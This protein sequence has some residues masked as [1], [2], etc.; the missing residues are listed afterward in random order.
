MTLLFT[1]LQGGMA[2]AQTSIGGSVYGG[3]EEADVQ[4]DSEVNI[5]GGQVSGNVYGGGKM[6]SVGTIA[7]STKTESGFVISVPYTFEYPVDAGTGETTTGLCTVNVTGGTIGGDV[8]G[9]SQGEAG[10]SYEMALT[11][12]IRRAEVI[13]G[14]E[15][16][17]SA[18][19]PEIKGSVYGG[20]ENGHTIEDAYVTINGG[21]IG[22][23]VFGSG[24][25]TDKYPKTLKKW[26]DD[27]EYAGEVYSLTAGKVY[28]NAYV[29]MKGGHVLGN[30]YGGGK[31][32]SIGKGNYSGGADDYFP[33]GY[34]ETIGGNLWD[35]GSAESQ[36]FLGT[37]KASVR[38]TGGTIGSPDGIDEAAR[39]PTGNVFGGSQGEAAPN[40]F[41]QPADEY[42]PVF[43]VA[44]INEAE[45]IIGTSGQATVSGATG[46]AGA[47]PRIYGSVYGGGQDG[48]IRR[49]AK[50]TIYSGEIGNAY[51][52]S[53]TYWEH[54]GNVFGAGSGFGLYT[55]DYNHNGT[56]YTDSN[57]NGRYDDGEPIDT[58][59]YT[60][61]DEDG[62][63][64]TETY[65][66]LGV[67]YLA[68][69]VARFSEVDIQGGIIHR[70]VYGGGSVAGTGEP[71]FG[72]QTYEPYRKGDTTEGHGQ[73]K[74]SM[75][76]VTVSGGIIGQEGHGGDVYGASRGNE[77]LLEADDRLTTSIWTEVNI[78]PN[79]NPANSPVIYGS[80]YGGG[81]LGTVKQDTK[82]NLLGGEIK[83]D[84]Y[85][86][87]K[88]T[89]NV[90]ADIGSS[91]ESPPN[92][93]GNTKVNLN[94]LAVGDYNA[95]LHSSIV[96]G[97]D[98]NDDGTVDYYRV[99]NNSKG[100]IVR[101]IFGCNNINGTPKGDAEVHVYATQNAAGAAITNPA[102]GAQTAKV[103]G[104]YDVQAVY[105]GGNQSAYE[106]VNALSTDEAMKAR[107]TTN[108][109]IDGCSLTS[110]E[111]V[112][113][114][115][116]AA[117]TPATSVT[118]NGTFEI[119][120]VFGG[121]NGK[122]KITVN[123]ALQDNP[124][125]NVGFRDY[126]DV[127]DDD[128]YNTKEKR[129]TN[130]DFINTYVY[131]SG[132]AS[133]NIFGGKIHRVFGGSNTKG[134]VRKTAVTMLEEAS[135]CDFLVDEAYGGGKSAPMDAEAQLLMECIPGLSAV[136]G[137]AE[138]ADIQDN[139]VLNI[140]NGTF[141]RV[142]GGN[143][144]SGTIKGT[145][146]VNIQETGC[147]PV[148]IGQLYGGGNQAPYTAPTGQP[149]P[150]VN[151]NS[152]TR[153]GEVYGG[154]YG[155]T[156]EVVGDTH[157]NINVF[158][159]RFSETNKDGED[160]V[161]PEEQK[162]IT[163]NEY[164]RTASGDFA[165]DGEGN[166]IVDSKPITLTMPAHAKGAIGSIY[167]VYGGGNAAKVT[168]NTHVNIGTT[169]DGDVYEVVGDVLKA[170]ESDVSSYYTR[171]G[172]G[173]SAS[174]YT[175]TEATGTAV[176]NTTYYQKKVVLGADIQGNIYGGG[177]QAD[178]TGDTNVVIGTSAT[179]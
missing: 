94:G 47:A 55:Y 170:G 25:G 117:S 138:A 143:N 107:A 40:I 24:K 147:R 88:G 125:A 99:G 89:S 139:V 142:F 73:G 166:R 34:G 42:N 153:I 35:G 116:N 97:I 28:G 69:C 18:E 51:S 148:I 84:A 169:V 37:G 38:I 158:E 162:T 179:E 174:P 7:S 108:V 163:F 80:V 124:G 13:I 113:G 115:G 168:G 132:E 21:K 45:V 66:D 101:R 36:A 175:Y 10:N 106:P 59:E 161:L 57:G 79:A 82:V 119:E 91:L 33:M 20:G 122:D 121:G 74:Q 41:N 60:Y 81:E 27:S 112:Y 54:R 4:I 92:L 114:G 72:M 149:G 1:L 133:V 151:V 22:E 31:L 152:F 145:I 11:A 14:E 71:K 160:N 118:V 155:E 26:E 16:S 103:I 29:V 167:N 23:S 98:E 173:T 30:V 126:S 104:R 52:S 39:M 77:A 5:S 43:H 76:I 93:G 159:G 6:G 171:S 49:D 154:G 127:E 65:Y 140:T 144:I 53:D 164:R 123:G 58:Y 95:T 156:A 90:P 19:V 50:V 172:E 61:T 68:G 17:T 67:S 46:T 136:Y 129:E 178:V 75:N 86:G 63:Q 130:A 2:M 157:V 165:L 135:P 131:G 56:T 150:T 8:F 110:I 78:L 64:R 87:G 176:A 3:G 137:G 120:E 32:A 48:H 15:G 102:E 109:I 111:Q 12:N 177:N 70:N 62:Q 83:G 105:G 134:N 146:T 9:A 96:E 100:C 141:D 44:N 85:G 128:R